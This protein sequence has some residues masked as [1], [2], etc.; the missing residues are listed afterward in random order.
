M[1]RQSGIK[2]TIN[3]QDQIGINASILYDENNF[4]SVVL[5]E[6]KNGSFMRYRPKESIFRILDF[7]NIVDDA[8][9][10]FMIKS[11]KEKLE[12]LNEIQT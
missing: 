12:K 8:I 9:D 10:D 1:V 3:Y 7:S 11:R 4:L 6:S 2:Y 5:V